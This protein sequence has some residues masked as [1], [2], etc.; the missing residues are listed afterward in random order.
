M[1]WKYLIK[2]IIIAMIMFVI[3]IFI[4]SALFNTVMD[5]TL[6]NQINE[7]I[8]SEILIRAKGSA[9]FD[10]GAYREQREKHYFEKYHLDEPYMTR[11][12][13]RTI[14]TV[15]FNFGKSTSLKS[16]QG[17]R[18]VKDIIFETIPRTLILFTTAIL[19]D[20][21]LGIIIGMKKAQ[22]PGSFMDKS[23]SVVTMI[24]YG[25]PSWWLGM[26][27]IM[28]FSY[29]LNIF[30]SGGMSSVP[31]PTGFA[32]ILDFLHHLA[33]PVIVLVGIGFWARAFLTR[34]IVLGTLQ[35]DYIMAA[36]ARG[37][38]ERSVIF[39]HG[40]RTA[41]PPLVTMSLLAI[42]TSVGGNLVFEGIFNWPGMGNLYWNA[43]RQNDVP[44]LLGNLSI[45]T[46]LYISGLV[47]LDIVYGLLDPR[48]KVG[49]K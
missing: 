17:S 44:V 36:R 18:E 24:V 3:L 21:F 28:F 19:I 49:G 2:R 22:K 30:P 6:K 46:G 11:V 20:I 37:I 29:T 35:E 12:L 39:G 27:M 10:S 42:L 31:T 4:F 48:I 14:D 5:R 38:K 23:T 40:L 41:A 43:V 13:W 9:S 34:N 26:I 15:T 7:M 32:Y 47:V 1:Y 8:N 16:S 25:M 33:L 45:T